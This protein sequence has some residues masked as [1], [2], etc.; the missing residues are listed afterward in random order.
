MSTNG[1]QDAAVLIA[2]HR[3]DGEFGFPLIVRA[4]SEYAHGGQVGLPGGR[5]EPGE[6]LENC[7]LRE[8]E[9][10]IA[11]PRAKVK[12]LGQLTSLPVPVSEHLIHTFVG[13]TEDDIHLQPD[14]REVKAILFMPVKKLL[15][16]DTIHTGEFATPR[17]T[18]AD[19]PYFELNEHHI[20]GATA[21]ILSELKALL[22][23]LG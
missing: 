14:S 6:S 9:E 23:D 11:L 10:E 20:W 5:L 19:V 2:L 17:G 3:C 7:A 18:L 13:L 4:E 16:R 1:Y 8:S 12:L 15:S 21:M 22:L